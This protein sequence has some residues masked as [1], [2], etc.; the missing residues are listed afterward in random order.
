MHVFYDFFHSEINPEY[1]FYWKMNIFT[2]AQICSEFLIIVN[3]FYFY[4]LLLQVD[5]TSYKAKINLA[6]LFRHGNPKYQ[7]MIHKNMVCTEGL[8]GLLTSS[9]YS[10]RLRFPRSKKVHIAP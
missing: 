4:Y 8:V 9:V 5:R 2:F 10:T 6:V 7:Y 1:Y 3:K